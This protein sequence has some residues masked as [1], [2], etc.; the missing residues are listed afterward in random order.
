MK[1]LRSLYAGIKSQFKKTNATNINQ[2][3]FNAICDLLYYSIRSNDIKVAK[4]ITDFMYEEFDRV[5]MKHSDEPIEFGIHLYQLTYNLTLLLAKNDNKNFN[6]IKDIATGGKWLL[7]E[8]EGYQ[9]SD[10]TYGWLW[11]NLKVAVEYKDQD[12]IMSFWKNAHQYISYRLNYI[13]PEYADGKYPEMTNQKEYDDRVKQRVQ[14]LQ[15]TTALGGLLMYSQ[16]Y[17]AIKRCFN[18]T[19]STPPK[20]ELLPERMDEVFERYNHFF[21]PY[22]ENYPFIEFVFNFPEVEGLNGSGVI[23]KYIC[24]YIAL[25]FLRQYSLQIYLSYQ[26]PLRKPQTFQFSQ[27]K[28]KKWIDSMDYFKSLVEEVYNDRH[29]LKEVGFEFLNDEWIIKN[30]KPHP[31]QFLIDFKQELK[32][33]FESNEVTQPITIESK[34]KF[35]EN[36]KNILEKTFEEYNKLN[37]QEPLT[38]EIEKG[39]VFGGTAMLSK[40]AFAADQGVSHLNFDSILASIVSENFRDTVSNSFL[41]HRTEHYLLTAEDVF[42]AIDNLNINDTYIL[43]AFGLRFDYLSDVLKIKGLTTTSYKGIEI[44]NFEN[45][46]MQTVGNTIFVIK[47]ENLPRFEYLD[48]DEDE[49]KKYELDKPLIEKYYLYANIIDLYLNYNLKIER[50]KETGEDLSKKVLACIA[51]RLELQWKKDIECISLSIYSEYQNKGIPN[52]LS[53]VK[54]IKRDEK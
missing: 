48:I 20:Y 24:K 11:Q 51:F 7:G 22:G 53:D 29:L 5:R 12:M 50:E 46:N 1:L 8:R 25:L 39:Y 44:R 16:L 40:E 23:K 45:A 31:I 28:R 6:Y 18:Y 47:K 43:M 26:A 30:E 13:F 35:L 3:R 36:T 2:D 32:Q 37:N 15:F 17:P 41:I 49:K 4:T 21:D 9:I 33:Q 19:Q 27:A 34:A 10:T 14:F 42:R 54:R 38:G 52:K